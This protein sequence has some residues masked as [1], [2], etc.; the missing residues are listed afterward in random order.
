MHQVNC[1]PR[2][3]PSHQINAFLLF[4][5]PYKSSRFRGILFAVGHE[6]GI[7]F[8]HLASGGRKRSGLS[9]YVAHKNIVDRTGL[10]A[11]VNTAEPK[12][13]WFEIN[14]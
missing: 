9:F 11:C 10:I 13:V 6:L 12:T 2:V 8:Q 4:H 7:C 3:F 5:R 14:I 1:R